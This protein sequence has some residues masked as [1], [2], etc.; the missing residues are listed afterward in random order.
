MESKSTVRPECSAEG[1]K[2]KGHTLA[3]GQCFDFA[4]LRSATLNTNGSSIP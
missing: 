2:S 1:A 3:K 4:E